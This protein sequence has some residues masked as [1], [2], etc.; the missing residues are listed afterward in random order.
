M[1]YFF[2]ILCLNEEEL[3]EKTFDELLEITK[4]TNLNNYK[5]YICND[6]SSDDTLEIALKIKKKYP[7]VSV[8]N[9]KKNIGP[10]LCVKNF[11]Q[12]IDEDGKFIV[13]GGDN[14]I[15][16]NLLYRLVKSSEL[17]DFVI[18]YYLNREKKGYLRSILS[19]AFNLIYCSLFQVYA[20]YLQG[21]FVWP[22]KEVKNLNIY[23]KG[24]AYVGEVNTKL[25][26]SGLSY[27]EVGGNMNTGSYA[28]TSVKLI[29]FIDIFFTLI[30]LIIEIYFKKKHQKFSRRVN[31]SI[32]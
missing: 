16:K 5:V 17:A 14:D 8:I 30:H 27:L 32:F 20:F 28:S 15:N 1:K 24:I 10:S 29:N 13:L 18:S 21:P 9:N 2:L 3:L 23:S 25:L 12:K 7:F 31:S 6:G 26:R 19:S 22:I 4:K 11:L